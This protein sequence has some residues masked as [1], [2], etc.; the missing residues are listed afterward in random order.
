MTVTD[1]QAVITISDKGMTAPVEI[2]GRLIGRGTSERDE[3][4]KWAVVEIYRLDEGGYLAHR[5]G[6]SLSYH[7][8][9]TWCRTRAGSRPGADATVDDLP[10]EAVPCPDCR[11]PEP[12]E[13][14]DEE[15]I[16]YEFPRHT[17]D[18]CKNAA[19]VV[20][21]LTVIRH[22]DGRAPSVRF[23]GPVRA[24]L[25]QAMSEDSAFRDMGLDAVLL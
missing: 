12:R 6:Y 2:H 8:G 11:P 15:K 20:E 18:S 3:S 5:A 1:N 13:L 14:G 23:S 22:R 21:H 10:D 19:E 7:R 25:G 16:R 24:A 17:F 4:V 9:D